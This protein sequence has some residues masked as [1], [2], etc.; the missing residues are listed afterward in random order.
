MDLLENVKLHLWLVLFITSACS[1]LFRVAASLCVFPVQICPVG[2]SDS[3]VEHDINPL[4]IS[5]SFL[6]SDVLFQPG[7]AVFGSHIFVIPFN[8]MVST[9]LIRKLY[10]YSSKSS[11]KILTMSR[12]KT[13]LEITF[14]FRNN[15]LIKHCI[16]H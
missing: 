4:Y 10:L 12:L 14:H 13:L 1:K 15:P 3:S 2:F 16:G 7:N 5:F 6:G 9:N 11:V 8:F